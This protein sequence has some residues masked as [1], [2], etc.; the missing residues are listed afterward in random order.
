[1]KIIL[2]TLLLALSFNAQATGSLDGKAIWC[3]SEPNQHAEAQFLFMD[4]EDFE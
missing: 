3:K 4:K 2:T 1:M